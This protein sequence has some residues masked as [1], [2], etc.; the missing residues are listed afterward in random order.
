MLFQIKLLGPTK[1]KL[2]K[3]RAKVMLI[4]KRTK[5]LERSITSKVTLTSVREV[6]KIEKATTRDADQVKMLH[7]FNNVKVLKTIDVF[8]LI[9]PQQAQP[10]IA[11]TSV[12]FFAIPVPIDSKLS[13]LIIIHFSD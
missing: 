10:K 8:K 13:K 1:L 7:K 9:L 5:Q 3:Q 11:N 12:K 6:A 4:I 2:V